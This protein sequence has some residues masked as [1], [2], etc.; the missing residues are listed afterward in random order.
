MERRDFLNLLIASSIVFANSCKRK[1]KFFLPKVKETVSPRR[2]NKL[3]FATTFPHRLFPLGI[4]V[5]TYEDKPYRIQRNENHPH[6]NGSLPIYVLPSLYNLYDPF[7]FF[8]PRIENKEMDINT[9]LEIFLRSINKSIKDK[10]EII[11]IIQEFISPTLLKLIAEIKSKYNG[12]YFYMIPSVDLLTNQIIANQILFNSRD[13]FLPDLTDAEIVLNIGSDFMNS[14]YFASFYLSKL[15]SK[16]YT[17][18]TIENVQSLTG[19]NSNYRFVLK[20]KEYTNCLLSL[21]KEISNFWNLS[22]LHKYIYK[23]NPQF[24]FSYI[25]RNIFEIIKLNKKVKVI[26]DPLLHPMVHILGY[27]LEYL[28]NRESFL[29]R[30]IVPVSRITEYHSN[31]YL[32]CQSK[33]SENNFGT[34]VLFDT[35]PKEWTYSGIKDFIANFRKNNCFVFSYY[36]NDFYQVGYNCIPTKNFLEYWGDY[37]NIDNSISVQQPIVYPLNK[38][39]IS[40]NELLVAILENLK[41]ETTYKTFFDYFKGYY[42]NYFSSN[43]DFFSSISNGIISMENMKDRPNGFSLNNSKITKVLKLLKSKLFSEKYQKNKVNEI[44][45]SV[46][47]SSKFFDGSYS[48]NPYLLELPDPIFGIS[49]NDFLVLSETIANKLEM[50]D[51]DVVLIFNENTRKRIELPIIVS[52]SVSSDTGFF[53]L[54]NRTFFSN[55]Y[56]TNAVTNKLEIVEFN[57]KSLNF[58]GWSFY[59]LDTRIIVNIEK[60]GEKFVLTRLKSSSR[61]SSASQLS[62]FLSKVDD[63][64]CSMYSLGPYDEKWKLVVD[65]DKC[66]GCNLCLL[67]CQLENNIPLVGEKAIQKQRDLYWIRIE[68]FKLKNGYKQ[69]YFLPIMCQQCDFAPCEAVCPA[70]ATSHSNDGINEMTYNRCIGSRI[71]MINCPYQ[72]RRFNF[73]SYERLLENSIGEFKNP[74]VTVRSIGVSEKCNFCIHRLRE[75]QRNEKYFITKDRYSPSTACQDACPTKAIV[76]IK[77]D[78]EIRNSTYRVLLG[79]FNTRPNVL[80]NFTLNEKSK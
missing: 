64:I 30:W 76:L 43:D 73:D 66:I 72:A 80:Y 41:N 32:D 31:S 61:I 22:W 36:P 26:I 46:K 4:I 58:E 48:S 34:L 52:D 60:S 47:L 12:F 19:M 78:V 54:G 62:E 65:I 33:L 29:N 20:E 8:N 16:K 15:R 35:N 44:F 71:C 53:Y 27:I 45:L 70:G 1:S 74:D 9:A 55:S 37:I 10:K 23:I 11:F 2:N 49:W 13:F 21:L 3:H 18:I 6:N 17:L 40:L 51:E 59:Y 38:N 28:I 25:S 57:Y 24:R 56:Q 69:F 14:D 7:R 63:T 75:F 68:K 77:G 42:I 50:R 67:A 79:N 39:S 5:E